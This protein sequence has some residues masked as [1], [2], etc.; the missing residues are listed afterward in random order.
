MA[1]YAFLNP[2]LVLNSVDLSDHV[3]KATLKTSSAELDT[4]AAGAT[5]HSRIGG[6]NDYEWTIEFNQDFAASKVDATVFAALGTV[7]ALTL[8]RDSATTSATNPEFQ[9]NALIS[10]YTPLDGAIGDLGIVSVTWK[11]SGTLTRAVS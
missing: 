1:V 7:V 6:L 4:T 8:K 9:G 5:Y 3:R 2:H 11:G 10:D